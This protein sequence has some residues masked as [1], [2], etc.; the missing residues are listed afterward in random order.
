MTYEGRDGDF[1]GCQVEFDFWHGMFAGVPH[2]AAVIDATLTAINRT[3]FLE[4]LKFQAVGWCCNTAILMNPFRDFGDY[5]GRDI[6]GISKNGTRFSIPGFSI[7][8]RLERLD[9]TS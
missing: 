7:P 2:R 6:S 5:A 8:A 3:Q 1:I 9:G 4:Y